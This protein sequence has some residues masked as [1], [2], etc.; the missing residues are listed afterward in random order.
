MPSQAASAT[1]SSGGRE[2]NEPA[3]G[4]DRAER[5]APVAAGGELQVGH[6]AVGQ[7]GRATLGTQA[8]PGIAT[9]AAAAGRSTGEIGSSVRRSTGTCGR[10]PV[11]AEHVRQPLGQLRVGVEAEHRV[12]LRQALGQLRAVALGQ[13][14]HRDHLGPGL[15]GRVGGGQQG[16][17]G[18]LLGLLDEAAGVHQD[19]VRGV[20][21]APSAST[22]SQPLPTSRPASSSESTSL[23]AQPSVTRAARRGAARAFRRWAR[24]S[25]YLPDP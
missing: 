20:R 18:V 13:A 3:E 5:A 12:G 21:P 4:R 7:P 9:S 14:A 11:P 10:E 8:C 19:H 15:G 22:S 1:T 16:V 25:G 2:T 6:R 24:A 17:D 23:R